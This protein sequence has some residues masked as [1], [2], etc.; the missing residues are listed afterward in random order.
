MK[1]RLCSGNRK[2][3][4]AFG[5][6]AI[7]ND[8]ENDGAAFVRF[9]NCTELWMLMLLLSHSDSKITAHNAVLHLAFKWVCVRA[10]YAFLVVLM[11]SGTFK[12][13]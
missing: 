7:W 9:N 13:I 8:D 5:F 10:H 6:V 2:S 3:R 12:Y 4:T 1:F 11:N